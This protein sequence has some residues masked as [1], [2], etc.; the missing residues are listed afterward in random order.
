[1]R[2]QKLGI[3]VIQ[4]VEDKKSCLAEYCKKNDYALQNV[5][6]IGNDVNDLEAMA[7]VGY[8][9]APQNASTKV[10]DISKM[11]IEQNGGDG[12]IREFFET[13]LDI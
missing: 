10:K 2:A 5:V 11:L 3:E 1:V 13:I 12:V 8:P 6:Y 7:S 9:L 4:G